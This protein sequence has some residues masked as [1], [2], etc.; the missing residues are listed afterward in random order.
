MG[1]RVPSRVS[2]RSLRGLLPLGHFIDDFAEPGFGPLLLLSE[3]GGLVQFFIDQWGLALVGG[4]LLREGFLR[5]LERLLTSF[6]AGSY[7]I[8]GIRHR[9]KGSLSG[10]RNG[11]PNAKWGRKVLHS[12]M[13]EGFLEGFSY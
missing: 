2:A 6:F 1:G 10:L 7:T 9:H 11:R 4:F 12:P 8:M 5:V 13:E 3:R